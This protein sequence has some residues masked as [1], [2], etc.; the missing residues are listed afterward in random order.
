MM[1]QIKASDQWS[2]LIKRR[3]S[4]AAVPDAKISPSALPAAQDSRE[5]GGEYSE[6]EESEIDAEAV[7]RSFRKQ[8]QIFID[9]KFSRAV[10]MFQIAIAI[11][12]ADGPD[13]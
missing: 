6:V 2:L 7:R 1:D 3:A 10:T 13:G 9:M 4:R 12:S 11:A 8:K 5:E